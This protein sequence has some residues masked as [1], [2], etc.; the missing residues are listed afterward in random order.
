VSSESEKAKTVEPVEG[1]G[2]K[3]RIVI[4]A[5]RDEEQRIGATLEAL[6]RAFPGARVL[7]ADD[8]SRDRTSERAARAGAE[9]VG[10]AGRRGRGK[11]GAMTAAARLVLPLAAGATAPTIVLCD[12]DLGESA[13]TLRPLAEAVESGRCDL[14]V[15][16]FARREGGGFGVAVGFARGAIR[17][18]TGLE[19]QAP[20]SGQRALR[21]DLL[22]K[23]VPFA[24]GFGIEIGMTVDAARA[25][26]RVEEI[27]LDL[28]HRATGR[29]LSGFLHRGRQLLAFARVYLSRRLRR[30]GRAG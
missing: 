18:L 6:W 25:G 29:T 13:Q 14:A 10:S 12:G 5:A 15:A 2:A 8:G 7:V 30:T 24:P 17:R 1:A 23:L 28:S 21:G 4:V 16:G 3:E 27:E 9:L 26:A 11:G 19:L 22:P 20:I